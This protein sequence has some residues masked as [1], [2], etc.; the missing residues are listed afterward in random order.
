MPFLNQLYT[1]TDDAIMDNLKTGDVLLFSRDPMKH[2]LPVA[3][4]IMLFKY[5]HSTEF[6][7]AACIVM[8][9]K[10]TPHVL[11]STFTGVKCRPYDVRIMQSKAKQIALVP[12]AAR[13]LSF[14]EHIKIPMK[15]IS[16]QYSSGLVSTKTNE[17]DWNFIEYLKEKY[18][19]EN[20]LFSSY[21]GLVGSL[22]NANFPRPESQWV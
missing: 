1:F 20:I 10:G 6:D 14:L 15:N 2:Y 9:N 3:V 18:S 11:E 19:K 12:A 17:S 21:K 13:K 5:F 4:Y 22:V 16:L 7:H 8:D